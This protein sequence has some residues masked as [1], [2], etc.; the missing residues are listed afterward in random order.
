MIQKHDLYFP[1]IVA[2]CAERKAAN[3]DRWRK[4]GGGKCGIEERIIKGIA[5]RAPADGGEA[6]SSTIQDGFENS[7]QHDSGLSLSKLEINDDKG[8]GVASPAELA[9]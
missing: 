5:E 4:F 6:A 7:N 2:L 9:A 1:A 3:L 8:E